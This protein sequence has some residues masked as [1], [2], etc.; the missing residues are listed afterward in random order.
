VIRYADDLVVCCH[1]R[2][3]AEQVKAQLAQWLAPRGLAFNEDKTRIVSLQAG[4]DFLGFNVRRYRNGKLLIKPS[5]TTHRPTPQGH[6]RGLTRRP[7]PDRLLGQPAPPEPATRG[8]QHPAT[9]QAAARTLHPLRG[10]A[11]AR[12]PGTAQP[13]QWHQWHR[14]TRKA[15]TRQ[16]IVASG[17]GQS[18]ELRLV[19]THCLNRDGNAAAAAR[20]ATSP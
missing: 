14:T 18:D 20:T 3:Q 4:Y 1:T 11:R 6:R 15:I 10:P 12:R 16:Y 19:H 7:R 13:L 8:P 5:T 2:Q 9:A 17:Q